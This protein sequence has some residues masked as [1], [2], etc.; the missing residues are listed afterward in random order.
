MSILDTPDKWTA[1]DSGG[2]YR[3]I[4]GFPEQV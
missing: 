4:Y 3:R 1:L 2:M